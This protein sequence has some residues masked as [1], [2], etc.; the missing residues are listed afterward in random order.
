VGDIPDV[1]TS[2]SSLKFFDMTA[3]M[4]TGTFPSSIFAN[5]DAL[6][7]VY[8]RNNQL[9]GPLPLFAAPLL[10]DLY[11]SDNAFT[12]TIPKWT[13]LP[14]L[15]ELL[16]Q[17]NALTGSVPASVCALQSQSLEDL[18]SDCISEILCECCTRCF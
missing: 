15:N 5:P 6:E 17:G 12:G 7:I 16:L 1:F 3:N 18:W 11:V 8:V 10:R 9:S 2:S 14:A 13:D 4:L